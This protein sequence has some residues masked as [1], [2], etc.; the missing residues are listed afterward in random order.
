A[1]RYMT[2]IIIAVFIAVFY[3]LLIR[4]GQKQKKA[5]RELVSSVKK[6]DEV[7]TAGGLFGT[8]KRVDAEN[9]IMEIAR[10]TEIKMAKSSIARVV[11][12]EDFEE[13]E[14]DYEED[15]EEE[16]EKGEEDSGED[17]G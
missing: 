9:V 1:S 5:H 11:N 12:A 16:N 6:G 4:P 13:E 10:K 7:M 2:F 14:E 8:I 15:Y 17:E 3:F